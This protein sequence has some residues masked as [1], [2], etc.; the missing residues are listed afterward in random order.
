MFH[1][2][3]KQ[4]ERVDLQRSLHRFVEESYSLEQADEHRD[5]FAEVHTLRERCRTAALSEKGA[6]DTVRL[7]ARYYRLLTNLRTRFGS[8]VD[9]SD[10]RVGFTWRDAWHPAKAGKEHS[11]GRSGLHASTTCSS[12]ARVCCSTSP[13]RSATPPPCRS[14]PTRTGRAERAS[15]SSRRH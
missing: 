12:S 4:T 15:A 11:K 8:A 10:G 1:L 13:P 9:D 2:P 6:E 7:L 3:L 14:A 5:A